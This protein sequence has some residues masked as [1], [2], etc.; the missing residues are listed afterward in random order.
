MM[1][2]GD[3]RNPKGSYLEKT[4][5]MRVLCKGE[6]NEFPWSLRKSDVFWS[7]VPIVGSTSPATCLA[8]CLI[9]VAIAGHV[10]RFPYAEGVGGI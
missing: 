1:S 3:W 5:V 7:Q 4:L 8:Y 10:G 6:V 9:R 2:G